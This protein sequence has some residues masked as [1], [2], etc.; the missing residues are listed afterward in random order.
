MTHLKPPPITG[1]HDDDRL[2]RIPVPKG[3]NSK[4]FKEDHR[5]AHSA[6]TQKSKRDLVHFLHASAGFPVT[7]T[8]IQAIKNGQCVGWPGL[9]P[10]L[11]SK[12]LGKSVPTIMGHMTKI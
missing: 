11:V 7:P 6:H 8:W 9:T 1:S 12:H 5:V 4:S 10:Q 3:G 2:W